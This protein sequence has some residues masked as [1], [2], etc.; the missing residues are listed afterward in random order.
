MCDIINEGPAYPCRLQNP[1]NWS[2]PVSSFKNLTNFQVEKDQI[3]IIDYDEKKS[4]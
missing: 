2:V 1:L 4:Q 3:E